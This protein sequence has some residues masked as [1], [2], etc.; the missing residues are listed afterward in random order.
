MCSGGD[1]GASQAREEEMARQR[2]ITQGAN[3]INTT[4]NNNFNDDFYT[5][6]EQAALD[7]YTPQYEQQLADSRKKL[8]LALA[9]QGQLQSSVAAEQKAQM[10]RAAQ[11]AQTQISEQARGAANKKRSEIE[12]ARSSAL[13][14][15]SAVGDPNAALLAAQNHVTA[16]NVT[17]TFDALGNLFEDTTSG[18]LTADQVIRRKSGG[19]SGLF[20]P[21]S[22]AG[23]SGKLYG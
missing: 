1:N 22:S 7:F 5:S 2:R 4:W 11:L 18:L 15:N 12:N 20:T 8:A 16:L 13:S 6:I 3:H 9:G 23:N 14:Q 10:D 17:P 21:S 19:T